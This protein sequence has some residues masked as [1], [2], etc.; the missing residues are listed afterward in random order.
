MF[1][2]KKNGWVQELQWE[3]KYDNK[4]HESIRFVIIW[5]VYLKF[6]QHIDCMVLFSFLVVQDEE[7]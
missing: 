6:Q 3:I 7:M 1:L 5:Q 4:G 2:E